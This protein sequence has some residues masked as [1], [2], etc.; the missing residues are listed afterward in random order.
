MLVED[1][2][3]L[4]RRKQ[5]KW[6]GSNC[7]HWAS[8]WVTLIEGYCSFGPIEVSVINAREAARMLEAYGGLRS[9]LTQRLARPEEDPRT[10]KV[11]DLV[12]LP[13]ELFGA[14][15]ICN[16]SSAAALSSAGGVSFFE[17]NIAEASWPIGR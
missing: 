11:G 10:A 9:A 7:L 4:W 14:V 16:G 5:F 3:D 8:G 13:G 2:V 15:G 6:D 1:Y 12:L 17:M